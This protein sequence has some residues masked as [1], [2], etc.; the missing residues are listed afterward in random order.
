MRAR[1]CVYMSYVYDILQWTCPTITSH[2]VDIFHFFFFH[3]SL[4]FSGSIMNCTEFVTFIIGARTFDKLFYF[5]FLSTRAD[6]NGVFC[7]Y[8]T[9]CNLDFHSA[10]TDWLYD[11]PVALNNVYKHCSILAHTGH[12]T[13]FDFRKYVCVLFDPSPLN[14]CNIIRRRPSDIFY[15]RT[16][17]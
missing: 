2:R 9:T 17:I 15:R 12:P 1:V 3:H 16:T 6:N 5:L 10:H 13:G 7:S 11:V 8:R 14:L 4:Y